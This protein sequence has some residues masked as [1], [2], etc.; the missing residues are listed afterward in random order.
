MAKLLDRPFKHGLQELIY[1]TIPSYRFPK[2]CYELVL[3]QAHQQFK[4]WLALNTHSNAHITAMNIAI[5][6]AWLWC[7]SSLHSEWPKT[8]GFKRVGPETSLILFC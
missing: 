3:E 1:N 5:A 7:F 4:S 8:E 6:R 2:I